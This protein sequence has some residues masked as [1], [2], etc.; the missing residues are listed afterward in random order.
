MRRTDWDPCGGGNEFGPLL[1]DETTFFA[2][3]ALSSSFRQR[4]RES[5]CLGVRSEDQLSWYTNI[6]SGF[7]HYSDHHVR[8]EYSFPNPNRSL[9]GDYRC[10]PQ[11]VGGLNNDRVPPGDF[12]PV[13]EVDWS[14][15]RDHSP[16]I[17]DSPCN[18]ENDSSASSLN[19]KL[20][21]SSKE[22]SQ[23]LGCS[24]GRDFGA[25]TM[26]D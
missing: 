17:R 15:T 21:K 11:Y 25:V 3:Y 2:S 23:R 20:R 13:G 12:F 18:A 1:L 26:G 16:I 7:P 19:R 24:P 5:S 22:G 14:K 4:F 9:D 10:G 6:P 8:A